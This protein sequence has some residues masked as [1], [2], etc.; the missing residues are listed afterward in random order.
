MAA[1]RYDDMFAALLLLMEDGAPREKSSLILPLAKRLNVSKED[2]TETYETRDVS[3]FVDRITWALSYLSMAG[4]LQRPGRGKYAITAEGKSLVNASN[5][6]IKALVRKRV[7]E[8]KLLEQSDGDATQPE[9]A[10]PALISK[11]DTS[12]KTPKDQIYELFSIYKR[13][14]YEEIIDMIL[15]KTPESFERVVVQLLQKMGYGRQLRDAGRTTQLSRDGG[16]DG[17]IREDVLGLGRISIQAKRY[18]RDQSIGRPEVQAFAGALQGNRSTKGVF[19]TTSKFTR[20]AIDYAR[21]LANVT[22]VLIDGM[23]LAEYMYQYG[24]GVEIRDEFAIK[25]LDESYWDELAD[26]A[27][28]LPVQA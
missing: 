11:Q 25:D 9:K 3:I 14:K 2:Q 8:R 17:E 28:S 19:I 10:L 6:K 20:D 4:L 16:I 22:I 21:S 1:P 18:Q 12:G 5:D 15:S 24:L 7:S 23:Q 27:P 13:T 26:G